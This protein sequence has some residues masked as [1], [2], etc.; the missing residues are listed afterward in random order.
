[1][2]L[3]FAVRSDV[4]L[5][6]DGNEDAA[7]AGPRLLAVADGMGGHAAGEVASRLAIENVAPLDEDAPESD[8]LDALRSALDSAQAGIRARI[9]EDGTLEG[10]GTTLTA[11]LWVGTR[12]GLL[13]VGDSRAY[14]LRDAVLHRITHDHTYV[15][16]LV[17]AGQISDDEAHVHPRRSLITRALD[18]RSTLEPDLSVREVQA[19]DRYLLCTDGLCGVVTDD[20]M[21]EALLLSQ[22]GE[23][24]DR[25]VDLALRGGGPDNITVIVCDVV[26]D[27]DPLPEP[28]VVGAAADVDLSARGGSS[29][30]GPAAQATGR[31]A[32]RS[33]RRRSRRR[34]VTALV[35]VLLVVGLAAGGW[36]WLRSQY[37][38]GV[39]AGQ[40]A[41][42]QGVAGSFAGL[43]LHSLSERR[44]VEATNLPQFE[45][46][47]LDE[48]ISAN[49]LRQ[50]RRVADR[51]S[52]EQCG[53]AAA[54]A[55]VAPVTPS[56]GTAP[57]AASTP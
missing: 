45:R 1:M 6:R 47:R 16:E 30:A 28:V 10:M 55:S 3:R 57:C 36:L 42:F 9:A 4:G 13:H 26:D 35:A 43:S 31:G 12:L 41:I 17:D 22:P 38:V 46:E 53:G 15:Q 8:L 32:T 14:L 49:T 25:L 40:V 2:G 7:Y 44:P 21:R 39:H 23:A 24:A 20:T 34:L 18:G 33:R 27:E 37:F 52:A 5:L 11:V 50:A 54:A 48:G 19:G 56:T 51:L 29:A